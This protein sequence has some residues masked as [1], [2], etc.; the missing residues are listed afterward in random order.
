MDIGKL[1]NV[2]PNMIT[3][4]RMQFTKT[5]TSKLR[6]ARSNTLIQYRIEAH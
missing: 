3:I 1:H 5:M 6:T 4:Y 2:I